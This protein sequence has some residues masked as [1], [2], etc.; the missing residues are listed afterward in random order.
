MKR[1]TLQQE[2]LQLSSIIGAGVVNKLLK[3]FISDSTSEKSERDEI[4]NKKSKRIVLK[5]IK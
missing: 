3:N 5:R 4:I 1:L 2:N